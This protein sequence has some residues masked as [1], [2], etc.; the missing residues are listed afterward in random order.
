MA[1][2]QG[3]KSNQQPNWWTESKNI[4]LGIAGVLVILTMVDGIVDFLI[5]IFR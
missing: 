5:E 4:A 2:V 1:Y 3:R